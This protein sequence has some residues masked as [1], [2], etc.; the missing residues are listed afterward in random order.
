M[1]MGK[2]IIAGLG[3]GSKEDITPAVLEAVRQ[4]DVIVGYKYYFQFI[5]PY[6]S[7]GCECIDTG[8]KK[9]RERAEQAFALAEQGKTV[10]V[11]SS[12]DAG[13]YGMA[14]LIYEM[15]Q[16]GGG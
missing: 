8:M 6:V 11:I 7:E 1:D 9:E 15:S 13:I 16:R 3:P 12:G 10:V 2:I 14:P 5:E 4:A